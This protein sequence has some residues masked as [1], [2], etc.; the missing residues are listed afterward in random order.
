MSNTIS[1]KILSAN[2]VVATLFDYIS[3]TKDLIEEQK[4]NSFFTKRSIN[5]Y[6]KNYKIKKNADTTITF[7]K[8]RIERAFNI[9]NMRNSGVILEDGEQCYFTENF[10]GLYSD[11][12]ESKGTI[13]QRTSS[14]GDLITHLNTLETVRDELSKLNDLSSNQFKID[15]KELAHKILNQFNQM[16]TGNTLSLKK[17]IKNFSSEITKG[18]ER[19]TLQERSA[20]AN[21]LM[22]ERVAP[23]NDFLLYAKLKGSNKEVPIDRVFKKIINLLR[24]KDLPIL[25]EKYNSVSSAIKDV[26]LDIS[27]EKNKLK[28]I[29][30]STRSRLE[31]MES[32]SYYLQRIKEEM[33]E[34]SD[35][36]QRNKQLWNLPILKEC[37]ILDDI[38]I[39]DITKS[40]SPD[41]DYLNQNLDFLSTELFNVDVEE[42]EITE[43]E[44]LE[45]E[46][47]LAEEKQRKLKAK[48]ISEF[49]EL[50]VHFKS[51][52]HFFYINIKENEEFDAY[53]FIYDKL[54]QL[55]NNEY[56]I[57]FN[58]LSSV[59]SDFIN[60]YKLSNKCLYKITDKKQITEL[61][62]IY[63]CLEFYG[64]NKKE[65]EKI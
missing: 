41:E 55:S 64:I 51:N 42:V 63:P 31:M 59:V 24:K 28:R 53:D 20:L 26:Y 22:E 58:I 40:F 61:D 48:K 15:T 39:Q 44:K 33:E 25:E 2:R 32:S 7:E 16:I 10:L 18:E 27:E 38:S 46:V 12:D 56:N 3:I 43:K 37:V 4:N 1:I 6:I 34:N 47:F 8:D 14:K 19:L 45:N 49:N 60:G 52:M 50:I 30:Q 9:E 35:Y 29:I 62:M 65:V 54:K 17:A 5:R 11:I 13:Y 21:D 23:F 57:T 36:K